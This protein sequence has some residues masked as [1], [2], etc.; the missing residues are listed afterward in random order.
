LPESG[1]ATTEAAFTANT[2]AQTTSL[3]NSLAPKIVSRSEWGA[4]KA[5]WS[6]KAYPLKGAVIHHTAGNN[7]YTAAQ[8]PGIVRSIFQYHAITLGWG[9]I[10]YNFLVDKYGV[11]YE[12]RSGSLTATPGQMVQGAHAANANTYSVGISVLGSYINGVQP[13]NASITAIE[14]ILAWQFDMAG[15]N[16][17]G[18]WTTTTD[19]TT[20]V[21][22]G[23]KDVGSTACPGLIYDRLGD[24][25]ANVAKII[26]EKATSTVNPPILPD[27][28]FVGIAYLAISSKQVGKGWPGTN[29]WGAGDFTS[30][31]F[32]DLILRNQNGEL[33]LYNG[34]ES[35]L[36][37]APQ[38]IGRGWGSFAD[39]YMG[40]DF[41]GDEFLDIVGRTTTGDLLLYPGNGNGGFEIPQKIGKGW[42]SFKSIT[43]AQS[44]MNK[45]PAFITINS[46]GEARLYPTNGSGT[47]LTPRSLG[48]RPDL[49]AATYVGDWD[50][51]GYSDIVA[52]QNNGDLYS[53]R[54][55]EEGISF[56]TK[57]GKGWGSMKKLL[58]GDFGEAPNTLYAINNSG[59]LYSYH[60]K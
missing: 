56:G 3:S 52:I 57:I 2:L 27:P 16:P 21:I 53:F 31:G 33:I 36:W 24:I 50:L 23:H 26:S 5:T 60:W 58:L 10:G 14:N 29:V 18:K 47:F 55:T 4:G 43:L 9:D 46:L 35:N 8:A 30:D 32:A 13:S 25:R 20:N 37:E 11:I 17:F 45:K 42:Q 28:E 6:P 44:G 19:I 7:V 12:G 34:K 41:N 59:L 51:D 48:K 1:I 15:I 49:T 54:F 22:A 39:L 40:V 38:K